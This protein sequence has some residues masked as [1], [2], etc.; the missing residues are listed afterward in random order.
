MQDADYRSIPLYRRDGTTVAEALVDPEDYE[1]LAVYRW[2]LG[3]SKGRRYARRA[4]EG[5]AI[6]MHRVVLGLAADDALH[7]DHISGDGLDNR[8]ENLRVCTHAENTQNR[9]AVRGARS[10]FRGVFKESGKSSW[11][12]RQRVN[13]KR[14]HLGYFETELAAAMVAEL[15]R[16]EHMP[17]AQPD[18]AVIEIVPELLPS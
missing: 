17:F 10:R 13:G 16:Q 11:R 4:E 6:L 9:P 14:T 12:A 7:C 15:W 1:A 18:R 2:H 3:R 5:H 8:R